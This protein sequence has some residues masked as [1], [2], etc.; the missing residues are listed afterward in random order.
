V[1]PDSTRKALVTGATGGIGLHVADRLT[2]EGLDVTVVGRDPGRGREAA[3]R[4]GGAT[5]FLQADLSSLAE[6]RALGAQVAAEGP[7]HLLVNNV[8]GM[9]S[10]RWETADGIEGSFALNHFSPAVLT[11]ALLDALRAGAPSRVV[12][13]TSSSI[14]TAVLDGSPTDDDVEQAG[15]FFGMAVTGRAKLAHLAHVRDLGDRLQGTGVT[16][17]AV[18]P[19]GPAAAATPNAAAMTPEILPTPLRHLWDQIQGGLRPA[20]ESARPIVAA[21]LDPAFA[22]TSGLVLGPDGQPSQDLLQFLTPE[23]AESARRLTRR[24]LGS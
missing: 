6:V 18:D 20:E 24:V 9:W 5:R 8:G 21:A 7:L 3:R 17:L 16:V 22:G 10:E 2:R 15:E 4:L 13:V 14:T 1:K 11:E 12:D 23:V 19:L